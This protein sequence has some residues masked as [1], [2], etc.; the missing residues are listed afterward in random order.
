[1]S[2]LSSGGFISQPESDKAEIADRALHFLHSLSKRIVSCP[3]RPVERARFD[4]TLTR[5]AAGNV[6]AGAVKILAAFTLNS[7]NSSN[8]IPFD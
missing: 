8:M 4:L 2:E 1:M 5:D 6:S 3:P 7:K